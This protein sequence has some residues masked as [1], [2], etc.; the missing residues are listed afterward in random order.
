MKFSQKLYESVEDIWKSYYEHPFVYGIGQGTLDVDKFKFYMIQDYIYLLDYAK[1]YALGIVKADTEEIMK[2]FSSMVN[3]ILNEEMSI[4]RSYM[5][6]LGITQ[7]EIS[8][9][10]ASLA[11]IS[12]TNYMLSVSQRGTLAELSVSLLS[13][14]WSY[15]EIGKHLSKIPGAVDHEFYGEW[16]RGYISEDYIKLTNWVIDLIDDLAKDLPKRELEKLEEIFI[17]TSK[18][19]YMFWDM[20][21]NKEM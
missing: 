10:K 16:I 18:Y 14:M 17:N 5:R 6:R 9:T 4:H 19:E 2:G 7:D 20:S 12:Y 15:L 13:C 3:G 1:I 21:Y 8:Q 11:N